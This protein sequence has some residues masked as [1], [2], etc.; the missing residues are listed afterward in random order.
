MSHDLRKSSEVGWQN[1]K[2]NDRQD[3]QRTQRFYQSN[4]LDRSIANHACRQ[5]IS[6]NVSKTI[7]RHAPGKCG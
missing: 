1:G 3:T 5:T 7:K 6:P 4:Y 2:G